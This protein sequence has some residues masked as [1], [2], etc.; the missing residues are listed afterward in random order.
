MIGRD[1]LTIRDHGGR[2]IASLTTLLRMADHDTQPVCGLRNALQFAIAGAIEVRAQQQVFR[3]VTGKRE[4][5]RQQQIGPRSARARDGIDNAVRV[6][7]EIANGEIKLGNS[8]RK[9]GIHGI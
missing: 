9:R 5:W 4:L 2:V 6:G 1:N 7:S 8:D 3:R